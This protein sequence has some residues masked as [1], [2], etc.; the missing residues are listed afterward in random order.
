MSLEKLITAWKALGEDFIFPWRVEIIRMYEGSE[1]LGFRHRQME[2]KY[3]ENVTNIKYDN[4]LQGPTKLCKRRKI[5]IFI[6]GLTS[7]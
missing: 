1:Y 5:S 4:E 7:T 2:N 3:T 6:I